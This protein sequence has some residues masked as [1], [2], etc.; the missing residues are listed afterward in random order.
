MAKKYC[1]VMLKQLQRP[2][3]RA[4]GAYALLALGYWV[5]D[6]AALEPGINHQLQWAVTSAKALTGIGQW[7]PNLHY[8]LPRIVELFG[9][10]GAMRYARVLSAT[11]ISVVV[12]LLFYAASWSWRPDEKLEWVPSRSIGNLERQRAMAVIGALTCAYALIIGFGLTNGASVRSIFA[13]TAD[14]IHMLLSPI[15]VGLVLTLSIA[16][17]VEQTFYIRRYKRLLLDSEATPKL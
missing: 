11:S 4:S 7:I 10:D 17:S 15:G 9:P 6:V 2:L 16:S 14:P 12:T 1:D 8:H 3:Y 5:L 13:P